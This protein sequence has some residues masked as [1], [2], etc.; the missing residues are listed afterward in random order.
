MQVLF[1]RCICDETKETT[2]QSHDP[3]SGSIGLKPETMLGVICTHVPGGMPF[4]R[5]FS[6][7]YF[8]DHHPTQCAMH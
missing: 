7:C 5:R 6:E 1:T 3:L 4:T 2:V 8:K